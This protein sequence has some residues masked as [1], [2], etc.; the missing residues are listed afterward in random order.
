MA[1]DLRVGSEGLGGGAGGGGGGGED[2]MAINFKMFKH[3]LIINN[4]Q[5]VAGV[6]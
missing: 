3:D 5:P 4:C 1:A 2:R 6:F